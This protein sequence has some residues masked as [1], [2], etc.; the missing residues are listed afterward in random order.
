[1]TAVQTK[2]FALVLLALAIADLAQAQEAPLLSRVVRTG[3]LQFGI[4]GGRMTLEGARMGSMRTTSKSKQRDEALNIRADNNQPAMNYEQTTANERLVIDVASGDRLTIRRTPRGGSSSLRLEFSQIPNDKIALTLGSGASR[5]V[6]RAQ[7]IWQLLITRPRE[8]REQLLPLLELL[9]PNPKLADMA[10]TVEERLVQEA[11]VD[12]T[13]QRARW[14]ALVAQLADESFAKREAADRAL[15]GGNARAIAYLR[16]LDFHRLDAEQQA[17]IH[18]I[19][20]AVAAQ[21]TEDSAEQVA[22]SLAGDPVIWLTLLARPQVAVRK[23]A[24]QQLTT[25]LGETIPIDLAA[26]PDT[27]KDKRE[28]LRAQIERE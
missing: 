10:A 11:G 17:R 14:A 3:W 19:L 20:D 6:F 9:R 21:N 26:D 12:A 27:Q 25:L 22:V 4:V 18:R 15:R 13:A 16:Q 23:A 2:L 28:Q 5:Q 1:M 8:C 24:A 7:G